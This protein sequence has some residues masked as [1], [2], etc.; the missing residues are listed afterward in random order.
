MDKKIKK[1]ILNFVL[2][3]LIFL[4]IDYFNFPTLLGINIAHINTELFSLLINSLIVIILYLITYWFID[5]RNIEKSN[6][7]IEVYKQVLLNTYQNCID[8]IEFFS[9][10]E[11]LLKTVEKVDFNAPANENRFTNNIIDLSFD[12]KD[13]I[14]DL[15]KSGEINVNTFQKY[16]LIQTEYRQY[17]NMMITLFDRQDLI[18]PLKA[19]LLNN[20]NEEIKN[21][22]D[23][24][25]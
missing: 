13:I 2:F 11:I 14:F 17:I 12:N 15:T 7:K 16:L 4:V 1:Y 18:V 25:K 10:E 8:T 5:K 21:V 24:E 19:K 23:K 6:N 9:Q 20:L 3:I 22:L